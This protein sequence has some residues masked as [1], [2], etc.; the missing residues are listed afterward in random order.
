[1]RSLQNNSIQVDHTDDHAR[2]KDFRN[3][4]QV[5]ALEK[6]K[7]AAL[8]G[9]FAIT[10]A[11]WFAL[12]SFAPVKWLDSIAT[13]TPWIYCLASMAVWFGSA[14]LMYWARRWIRL[15]SRTQGDQSHQPSSPR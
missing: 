15:S 6:D 7:L 12:L 13:I 3:I 10:I 1:M 11:G 14:E 5:D 2:I 9:G 8:M 4:E